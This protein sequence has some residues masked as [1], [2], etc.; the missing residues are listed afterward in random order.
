M[1]IDD[2]E[3]LWR[4]DWLRAGNSIDDTTRVF[5]AQ[6]GGL[7]IDIRIPL[8]RPSISSYRCLAELDADALLQLTQAEGFSGHISLVNNECTWHREINWHGQSDQ[9]DAGKLWF[10]ESADVLMEDGIYDDYQEQWQRQPQHDFEVLEL[11]IPEIRGLLLVSDSLFILGVGAVS[12]QGTASLKASLQKG[13]VPASAQLL[14][15]SQ[16]CL[17]R[18]DGNDGI[19]ELSTNPFC[20]NSRVVFRD[21][22]NIKWVQYCYDG[23]QVIHS[24]YCAPAQN[25]RQPPK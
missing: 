17:G 14:F 23:S 8:H 4:R 6:A 18:W 16:Y 10:N 11:D 1:T 5:W 24:F 2:L 21:G 13:E 25:D 20:E 19:A 15:S 12:A 22:E 9:I 7:F 3:G